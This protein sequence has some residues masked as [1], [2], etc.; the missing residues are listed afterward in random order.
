V[1]DDLA[2]LSATDLID[3]NLVGRAMGFGT[4]PESLDA[5]VSPRGYRLMSRVPRLPDVVLDRMVEHFGGLQKLLAASVDDLQAVEGVSEA[6]ARTI[7]E[8]ISRLADAS[9]IDRYP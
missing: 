1:L 9:I 4:A 6:R 8:A 3:I 5:A 7:R 2:D